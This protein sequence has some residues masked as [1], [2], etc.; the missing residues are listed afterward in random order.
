[1][2]SLSI[3]VCMQIQISAKIF[4]RLPERVTESDFK[5]WEN[6]INWQLIEKICTLRQ[7]SLRNST[8]FEWHIHSILIAF[9]RLGTNR[10]K[11]NFK[12]RIQTKQE[13]NKW[14]EKE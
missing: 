6:A 2:E 14:I 1:M 3:Q 8:P 5:V 13:Y 9:E 7:F 11:I 4:V 12:I 10:W